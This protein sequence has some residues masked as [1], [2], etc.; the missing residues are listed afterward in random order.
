MSIGEGWSL[1]FSNSFVTTLVIVHA[2]MLL[3]FFVFIATP[4]KRSSR[5]ALVITLFGICGGTIA[6]ASG[7]EVLAMLAGL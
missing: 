6:L 3:G 1:M 2:I 7:R 4:A 5:I